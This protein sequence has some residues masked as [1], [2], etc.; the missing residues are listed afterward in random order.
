MDTKQVKGLFVFLK[1]SIMA[2]FGKAISGSYMPSFHLSLDMKRR[3]GEIYRGGRE[4]REEEE[5][6]KEGKEDKGV[7]QV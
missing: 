5:E 3:G 6:E 4:G 7:A 1:R 2:I